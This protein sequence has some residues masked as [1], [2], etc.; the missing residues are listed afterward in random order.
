MPGERS[1][2][3]CH[4][5]QRRRAVPPRPVQ[6]VAHPGRTVREM[7]DELVLVICAV[8]AVLTL[9]AIWVIAGWFVALLIAGVAAILAVALAPRR[10]GDDDTPG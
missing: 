6:C 4:P 5:R 7:D 10:H 9:A 8:V 1:A 2:S 3:S